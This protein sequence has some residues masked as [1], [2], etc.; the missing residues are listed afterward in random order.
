MLFE[1][2]MQTCAFIS[3]GLQTTGDREMLK[4]CT[5][6]LEISSFL[7]VQSVG[8]EGLWVAVLLHEACGNALQGDDRMS[9]SF[10]ISLIGVVEGIG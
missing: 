10:I 8:S 4:K 6:L 9:Q 5:L 2:H 7:Y 3:H 1:G